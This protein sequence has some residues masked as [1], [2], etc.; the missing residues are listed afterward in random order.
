MSC[1][2]K[3][4]VVSFTVRQKDHT[5]HPYYID[6]IGKSTCVFCH[7]LKEHFSFQITLMKH[8]LVHSIE[9]KELGVL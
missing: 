6:Y 2:K 7:H 4:E 1:I 9:H 5:S 3:L 8:C